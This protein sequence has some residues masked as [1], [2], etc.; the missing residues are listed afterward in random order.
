MNLEEPLVTQR[1]SL[2][3]SVCPVYIGSSLFGLRTTAVLFLSS[4]SKII[5]SFIIYG[6]KAI[7]IALVRPRRGKLRASSSVPPMSSN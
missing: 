2:S 5:N 4:L 3:V 1:C 6:R 7:E